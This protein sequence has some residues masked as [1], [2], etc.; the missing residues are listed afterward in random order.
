[1]SSAV[2][3]VPSETITRERRVALVPAAVAALVKADLSVIVETG[4]GTQAGYG[5]D[6]YQE[7]GATIV[8]RADQIVAQA[9][10]IATVGAPSAAVLGGLSERHT[11]IGFQDPLGD[12]AALQRLAET[13]ATV[14]AFEFMPRI[15]RAQS[16]D[17]L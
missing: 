7:A 6:A 15:T 13:G 9:N 2:I 16:M 17:A 14:F 4:A 11:L 10:V 3:G 8:E 5:D 1:M 12:P